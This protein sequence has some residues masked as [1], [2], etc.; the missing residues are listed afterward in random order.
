MFNV[1]LNTLKGNI[2]LRTS[3]PV[4]SRVTLILGC[5]GVTNIISGSENLMFKLQSMPASFISTLVSRSFFLRVSIAD[6]DVTVTNP[7]RSL[8]CFCNGIPVNDALMAALSSQSL[9]CFKS[10]VRY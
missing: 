9:L 2:L 10:S 6:R 1:S 4:T 8:K 7:S 3:N 5:R